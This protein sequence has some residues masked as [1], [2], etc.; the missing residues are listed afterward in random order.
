MLEKID[1][2]LIEAIQSEWQLIAV[3]LIL[4]SFLCLAL[5]KNA[6]TGLKLAGFFLIWLLVAAVLFIKSQG[7][8]EHSAK[9]LKNVTPTGAPVIDCLTASLNDWREKCSDD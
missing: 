5:F 2:N 6:H 9:A 7:N 4:L 8:P 3:G 1:P